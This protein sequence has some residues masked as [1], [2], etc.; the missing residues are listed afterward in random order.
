[1]YHQIVRVFLILGIELN[2]KMNLN[3]IVSS[4]LIK[5]F[6]S[7][8]FQ[9][10]TTWNLKRYLSFRRTLKNR[11]NGYTISFSCC[12]PCKTIDG[13]WIHAK[14]IIVSRQAPIKL[15]EKVGDNCLLQKLNILY[16]LYAKERKNKKGKKSFCKKPNVFL[17]VSF[18][19]FKV[20]CCRSTINAKCQYIHS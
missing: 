13:V 14:K 12:N 16:N 11:Q 10:K 18:N 20:L 7:L 4:F 17:H 3:D 19:L 9:T 1:M 8:Y 6:W 5:I 2:L 15:M